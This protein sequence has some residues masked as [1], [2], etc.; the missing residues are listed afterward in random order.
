MGDVRRRSSG[1]ELEEAALRAAEASSLTDLGERVLP[2]LERAVGA[3]GTLLYRYDEA[4]RLAPLAGDLS[5]VMA[6]YAHHYIHHDPVQIFPRRLAPEPRVVLATRQVDPRAHRRSEA[7][8]EFYAAFGLE[9]LACAW[10]THLPYASPGMT[11]MLFTR[12]RRHDDFDVGDQRLLGRV[13][14]AL[15]AATARAERLAD[16]DLKRQ[17][18]E[19]ILDAAGGPPRLVLLP[20]GQLVWA[21]SAAERLLGAT[22]QL[23]MAAI[24][25]A[26]RRLHE[27][28]LARAALPP[29]A[30]LSFVADGVP[31]RAHLSLVNSPSGAPLVLV[32][33]E[34][35]EPR[36][37]SGAALARRFGLTAA[38]G[39]VLGQLAEG[40]ANGAIAARLHVSIETVRTHV[41]RI[42]GKLGVR[43]RVGAALMAARHR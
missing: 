3:S 1:G 24:R 16:L 10:L 38:E 15:A 23:P 27:A 19:A 33:I 36:A 43:S 22:P 41:R 18:L 13:L 5:T 35:D 4:G 6:A 37:Q 11:G 40:L 2:L 25:T 28:A 30:P 7:Y 39:T 34:G 21:S 20:S 8:G 31:R 26:A 32:E 9:H 17:A 14:P 42:L 12:T 29:L